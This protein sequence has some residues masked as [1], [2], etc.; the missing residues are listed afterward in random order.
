[1]LNQEATL[2]AEKLGNRDIKKIWDYVGNICDN[3]TDF[4]LDDDTMRSFYTLHVFANMAANMI[5]WLLE[6][7]TNPDQVY[8]LIYR[9][10]EL[11]VAVGKVEKKRE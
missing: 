6:A 8:D 1:M 3:T 4:E 7:D 9:L 11:K 2:F 10:V 5:S